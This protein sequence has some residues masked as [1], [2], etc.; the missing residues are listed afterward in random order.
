MYKYILLTVATLALSSRCATVL[1]GALPKLDFLMSISS[2]GSRREGIVRESHQHL[3]H[4]HNAVSSLKSM[5]RLLDSAQ[6]RC[7]QSAKCEWTLSKTVRSVQYSKGNHI[8]IEKSAIER[9]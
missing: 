7:V 8:Y 1:S 3:V 4:L 5:G 9:L 6:K 2:D